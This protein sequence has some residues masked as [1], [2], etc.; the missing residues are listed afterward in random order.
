MFLLPQLR[1]LLRPTLFKRHFHPSAAALTTLR[2]PARPSLYYHLLPSPTTQHFALSF[3]PSPPASA[4]S[5]TI[6]GY[7][8]ALQSTR[9]TSDPVDAYDSGSQAEGEGELGL[10]DFR[11]NAPFLQLLHEVLKRSVAE[12][13]AWAGEALA[14]REGFMP[15]SGASVSASPS[16]VPESYE[17]M[18]T[19]RVC[20]TDGVVTLSEGLESRLV[21]ELERVDLEEHEMLKADE[22]G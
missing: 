8:P 10:N 15:I 16:I 19:Y 17:P 12:D 13:A 1:S 21:E 20:T 3:L 5:K 14:R 7:L 2:D 11:E 4:R 6:I 18:P 9:T 22:E